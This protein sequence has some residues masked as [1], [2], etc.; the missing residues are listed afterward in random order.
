LRENL[1]LF[2]LAVLVA[3]ATIASAGDASMQGSLSVSSL[4][5]TGPTRINATNPVLVIDS[6]SGGI[7]F[8]IANANG[9]LVRTYQSKTCAA[10]A[11]PLQGL[12]YCNDDEWSQPQTVTVPLSNATVSLMQAGNDSVLMT[13][14]ASGGV[15][16]LR[17]AASSGVSATGEGPRRI[18]A[19]NSVTAKTSPYALFW[20]YSYN[21]TAAHANVTVPDGSFVEGGAYDAFLFGITY[22]VDQAGTR[23][24]YQSGENSQYA[25]GPASR[26]QTEKDVLELTSGTLTAAALSPAQLFVPASDVVLSGMATAAG[27]TGSVSDA[28]GTWVANDATVGLDGAGTLHLSATQ[29]SPSSSIAPADASSLL[30]LAFSGSWNPSGFQFLPAATPLL[31]AESE[32]VGAVAAGS[33]LLLLGFVGAIAWRKRHPG[34]Q[35]GLVEDAVLR[36]EAGDLAG[37]LEKLNAALASD[38]RSAVLHLDRA[39]C[40]ER[41]GRGAE[42]RRAF[43]MAVRNDPE[44]AEA[45][46]GLAKNLAAAGLGPSAIAHLSRAFSLDE[47]FARQALEEPAFRTISNHPTYVQIARHYER[48]GSGAAA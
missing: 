19:F 43:E 1:L 34:N 8:T 25:A 10:I 35:N 37:A 21:E 23:T 31:N 32:R 9:A 26:M 47:G 38:P 17:A 4:A 2:L 3:V 12:R 44:N 6:P 45:H 11:D 27:A 30:T 28:R 5:T 39:H 41:I 18:D 22:Q 29:G 16:S 48:P 20:F 36:M 46:Y 42:A 13:N 40:L 15:A 14:P 33:G 7:D 24:T